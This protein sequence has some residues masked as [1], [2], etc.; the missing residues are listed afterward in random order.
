MFESPERSFK[1]RYLLVCRFFRNLLK[2][3]Q[4]KNE[5]KTKGPL[6]APGVKTVVFKGNLVDET[7]IEPA[8][9]SLRRVKRR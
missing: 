1:K 6:Q 5:P 8:T 7:G 2:G 3:R 4:T 9:S